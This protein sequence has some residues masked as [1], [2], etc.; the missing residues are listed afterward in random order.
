M[1]RLGSRRQVLIPKVDIRRH[2]RTH[3]VH[4]IT[5]LAFV[6][7]LFPIPV[8]QPTRHDLEGD[9]VEEVS[10]PCKGGRCGCST[11]EKCWTSCCCNTPEQRLAWAIQNGVTP[12]SYAVLKTSDRSGKTIAQKSCCTNRAITHK[13][14]CQD[15]RQDNT[16]VCR[17]P[18]PRLTMKR[19]IKDPSRSKIGFGLFLSVAK[20]NGKSL[21]LGSLP[22]C[23]AP[24]HPVCQLETGL[25]QPVLVWD[26][27]CEK[28]FVRVD[29]PP[30][31]RIVRS[32]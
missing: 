4:W 21:D 3:V 17:H 9:S 5:L 6:A 22:P 24:E 13:P 7:C 26:L 2:F 30:P 32:V 11:A 8:A 16:Q 28:V 27:F 10:Y 15:C 1:G 29:I 14:K 20:C 23:I 18:S 12:P 25:S 19:E 31:K